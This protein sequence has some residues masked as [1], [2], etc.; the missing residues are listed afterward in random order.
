METSEGGGRVE[1]VETRRGRRVDVI[2]ENK[3][4]IVNTNKHTPML[5]IVCLKTPKRAEY[6]AV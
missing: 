5:F 4:Y 2:Y 3:L 1:A 6:A